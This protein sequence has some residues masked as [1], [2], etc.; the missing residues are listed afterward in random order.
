MALS[1]EK[2]TYRGY[3]KLTSEGT[4]DSVKAKAESANQASWK[5]LEESGHLKL[6][7]ND[8]LRYSVQDDADFAALVPDVEQRMYI[9]QA[10]LN[11]VQNSKANALMVELEEDGITPKYNDT[12]I[13]LREA[14]NEPPSKRS[15]SDIQKLERLLKNSGLDAAGIQALLAQAAS[16]F[17]TEVGEQEE[18]EA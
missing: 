3:V 1:T 13:D 2:V 18:V 6:N 5:K 17:T 12:E 11:Y 7:Q 16:R 10:G 8:F 9:V 15:L 4:V 14:I